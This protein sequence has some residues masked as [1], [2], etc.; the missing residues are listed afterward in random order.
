MT[1]LSGMVEIYLYRD[2]V[3][4]RKSINGLMV[5]VEDEMKLSPFNDAL[6]VFCNRGR[7]KIKVLYWDETG[8]CLWYKRLEKDKFK[9]PGRSN[10]STL[11]LSETQW[12]WLL[13]GLDL[14]KMNTHQPLSHEAFR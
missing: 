14:T 4:I 6:F 2:N 7:D 10:Q 12:N 11:N 1:K 3:D 13:S 5:V 9:W 8:F